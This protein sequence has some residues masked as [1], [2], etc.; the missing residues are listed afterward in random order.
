MERRRER[1]TTDTDR[2]TDTNSQSEGVLE[3]E[4]L[5]VCACVRVGGREDVYYFSIAFKNTENYAFLT[6]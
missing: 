3:R 2:Q 1:D 5:G 6:R 4:R